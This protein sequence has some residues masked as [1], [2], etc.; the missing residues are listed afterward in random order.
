MSEL[1]LDTRVRLF[2]MERFLD[3]GRAPTAAEIAVAVGIDEVEALHT[4]RRLEAGRVIV[5]APGGT[6]IWMA[7]PLSATPTSFRV[8]TERASYWGNC[9][10]DGL[11]VL[12]MLGSDGLVRTACADCG[13]PIELAVRDGALAPVEGLAHFAV[14]AARWWQ[15]IAFT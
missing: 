1:A 14:P 3:G 7:N 2:V 4:L 5:L 12:A 6:E 15:N 13:D 10:W 11:G 9:I 8:E